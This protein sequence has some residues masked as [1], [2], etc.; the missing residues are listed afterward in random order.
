MVGHCLAAAGSIE[1]CGD[2]IAIKRTIY[3]SKYQL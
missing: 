2:S 3:I 1:S